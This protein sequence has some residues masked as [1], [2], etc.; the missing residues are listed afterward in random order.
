[1]FSLDMVLHGMNVQIS[2]YPE[3]S[4]G[5]KPSSSAARFSSH[6]TPPISSSSTDDPLAG[7]LLGIAE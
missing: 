3:S 2:D 4:R 6:P 5:A 7:A 1:M